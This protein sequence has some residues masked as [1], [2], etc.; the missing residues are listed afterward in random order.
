MRSVTTLYWN[1]EERGGRVEMV[2]LIEVSVD[3]DDVC[4]VND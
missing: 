3:S 2:N 4:G 1:G